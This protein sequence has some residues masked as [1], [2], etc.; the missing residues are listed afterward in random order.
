MEVLHE[1]T[2]DVGLLTAKN[3]KYMDDAP[4]KTWDHFCVIN[5]CAG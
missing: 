1:E 4:Q 2:I 3:I 5:E